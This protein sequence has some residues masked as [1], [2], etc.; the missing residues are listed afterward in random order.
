MKLIVVQRYV[1]SN[2]TAIS[3]TRWAI[4]EQSVQSL[5]L[6]YVVKNVYLNLDITFFLS[7]VYIK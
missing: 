7:Y 3:L 1:V 5:V 4:D 6:V 2:S